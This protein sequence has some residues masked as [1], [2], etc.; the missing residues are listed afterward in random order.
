[1]TR[2]KSA[3]SRFPL[4]LGMIAGPL[5]ILTFI[6]EGFLRPNYNPLSHPVSSLS[7]GNL[8]W[9][10]TLNFII[11]G[12]FVLAFSIGLRRTFN[13]SKGSILIGLMGAGLLGAGIFISDPVYGYP[14]DLPFRLA[15][16]TYS[17]HLHDLFSILAFLCLPAAS[18]SLVHRFTSQKKMGWSRYSILTGVSM[19]LTFVIAVLGFKQLFLPEF[20]G[21]FQRISIIIGFSWMSLLAM[22]FIE[23]S[24]R[25]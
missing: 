3:H 9:I 24:N 16:Y 23:K 10:Q 25:G 19:L 22:Q 20:A 14:I 4:I 15:Q 21:I 6:I 5:F 1:M 2:N 13:S 12:I 18:F 7:I 17:G 11:T 8:G